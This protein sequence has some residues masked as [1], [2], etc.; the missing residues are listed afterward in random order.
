MENS[1]IVYQLK[2]QRNP[3]FYIRYYCI[4]SILF[5]IMT[6]CS[7]W[8]DKGAAPARAG[9]AITVI[10]ITI[11]FNKGVTLI[12]PPASGSIWLANYFMGILVFTII[13]MFEY[14]LLNYCDFIVK[15]QSTEITKNVT[16]IKNNIGKLL[17]HVKKKYPDPMPELEQIDVRRG[18][19]TDILPFKQGEDWAV[20]EYPNTDINQSKGARRDDVSDRSV[21][22]THKSLMSRQSKASQLI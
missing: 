10:L 15:Q 12:L 2:F 14:V 3:M 8:I 5:I 21:A 13:S 20:R 18:P 22:E 9:L 16:K 7:F 11:N 1:A 17:E 4:P 6:Y 19:E